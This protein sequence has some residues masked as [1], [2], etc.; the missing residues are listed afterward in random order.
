MEVMQGREGV[1]GGLGTVLD[2]G[3]TA[4]QFEPDLE[5]ADGKV[6]VQPTSDEKGCPRTRLKPKGLTN[7]CFDEVGGQLG[8]I[9]G[10]PVGGNEVEAPDGELC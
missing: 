4:I 5:V 10:T 2:T 9:L 3:V 1:A 8:C 7:N 6:V